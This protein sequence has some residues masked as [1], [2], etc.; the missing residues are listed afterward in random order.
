MVQDVEIP[1]ERLAE[2]LEAFH[3][4]I[5]IAPVWLCP[6]RL[7]DDR[8]VAALPAAARRAVRQRRVLVVG[9]AEPGQPPTRTTG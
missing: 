9:A 7:R 8:H 1:V 5:G 3:R 2:F 6:L 4:D